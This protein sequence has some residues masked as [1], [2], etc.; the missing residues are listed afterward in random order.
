M[1]L[2]AVLGLSG[3]LPA[4]RAEAVLAPPPMLALDGLAPVPQALVA[5]VAKYADIRGH[6]FMDWHPTRREMLISHREAGDS[7]AQLYRLGA[8]GA[9]LERISTGSEPI[10]LARYEPGQGRYLLVSRGTGGNE[11]FQIYRLDLADGK[12]TLLTDPSER[13]AFGGW[14]RTSGKA[15]FTAVPLDRTAAS[16]QRDAIQTAVWVVDPLR[17]EERR[18][19]AE[20]PGAGWWANLVSE[21]ERHAVFT[22]Y[23]S[24][25]RSEVWLLDLATGALRRVLPQHDQDPPATFL[26]S[27]LSADAGMLYFLTDS[28]GE[29]R[30]M[31]RLHLPS[32]TVQQVDT[33]LNWD[34][35]DASL[36]RNGKHLALVYNVD[37]LRALRV[38]DTETLRVVHF[39]DLPPGGV[40]GVAF[41]PLGEELMV[42]M[43]SARGPGEVMGVRAGGGVERWTRPV[44]PQGLDTARFADQQRI[45][46]RSFDGLPISGLIARPMRSFPGRR[47]VVI[48]IH[49]GP[50][51]QST[52]GF[53]G[54]WNYLIEERGVV[55]IFPNVRGSSGY[56]KGFLAL[57]N[58]V[59][60]ENAVK[61]IGALLDWVREQPD[62]DPDRVAVMGASYGGYMALATT[63]HYGDR[64]RCAINIVGITHFVSF[65]E[66]TESYRRDLRRAEYGDE[67][68]PAMR[69]FLDA[70]SPLSQAER[71]QRPLLVVHGRNDPRVPVSEAEQLVER[72]K[73]TRVPVWSML[74]GNEGH[75][76]VR[77]E[78]ADFQFYAM[79]VFLERYLLAE[80]F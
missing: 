62:L 16:G 63:I 11:A 76:F 3:L 47:P 65:L 49:G 38:V 59:L 71:L 32:G 22:R 45:S 7:I 64:I 14:L 66:R 36:A 12:K 4:V 56:G 29:F 18:K 25:S 5:T 40:L 79:L 30:Q 74:A 6:R 42:A 43:D 19:I 75:G 52:A 31:A 21:D 68:D 73:T 39:A 44:V 46:W 70:I 80:R 61:D 69:R 27:G 48:S 78:N 37:G 57:D 33:G 2:L 50:E 10:G 8:P 24:A 17:P 20:L 23:Q 41:D 1:L 51:A 67:R 26:A 60:R 53:L 15:L 13:Y 9:A 77:R 54:R 28:F 58:G 35:D 72:M 34:V 55:M